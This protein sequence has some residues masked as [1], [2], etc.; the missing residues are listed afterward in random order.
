MNCALR[1]RQHTLQA[2]LADDDSQAALA[3]EF[4]NSFEHILCRIIV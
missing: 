3:I 2:M 1:K 4:C